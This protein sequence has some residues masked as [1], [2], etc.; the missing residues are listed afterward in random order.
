MGFG[1]EGLSGFR[2]VGLGLNGLGFS[3]V[4]EPLV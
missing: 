2:F 1:F 3:L 4:L